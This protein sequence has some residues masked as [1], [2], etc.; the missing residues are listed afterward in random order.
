MWSQTDASICALRFWS[1]GGASRAWGERSVESGWLW[2]RGGGLPRQPLY[3][4][5]EDREVQRSNAWVKS[6]KQENHLKVFHIVARLMPCRIAFMNWLCFHGRRKAAVCVCW[7]YYSTYS[8]FSLGKTEIISVVPTIT[9]R[10]IPAWK[11]WNDV[12]R[13]WSAS[14]RHCNK[15]LN[16]G[17]LQNKT[18]KIF[19]MDLNTSMYKH[20]MWCLQYKMT[21]M[22][23][24]SGWDILLWIK[25]S[26]PQCESMLPC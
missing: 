25:M 17:G 21:H 26:Q 3:S 13:P 1:A 20:R 6:V 7:I 18:I 10:L 22:L 8:M 2:T 5:T 9:Q 16:N 15:V 4:S 14:V 23:K 24:M 11:G 19:F 12:L